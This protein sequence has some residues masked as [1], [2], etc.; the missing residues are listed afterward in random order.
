MEELDYFKDKEDNYI[1]RRNYLGEEEQNYLNFCGKLSKNIIF[2]KSEEK[3]QVRRILEM[4]SGKIENNALE[5]HKIK[6][7]EILF[8]KIIANYVYEEDI[9][10]IFQHME[11]SKIEK[12]R[13]GTQKA[14]LNIAY[15]FHIPIK[16]HLR[17][18]AFKT[19]ISQGFK[20]I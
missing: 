6:K 9:S 2:E 20:N 4:E 5:I 14:Q 16:K 3:E 1:V 19:L 15:E 7:E 13:D 18:R 8:E 10:P 11:E 17:W 12:M